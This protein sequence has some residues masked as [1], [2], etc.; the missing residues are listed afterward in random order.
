MTRQ[1]L[2]FYKDQ[3]KDATPDTLQL[4]VDDDQKMPGKDKIFYRAMLC[5][6]FSHNHFDLIAL[7]RTRL[8]NWFYD[9]QEKE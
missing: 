3:L 5:Y 4:M 2:D 8:A 7:L 1:T 9:Q 6:A